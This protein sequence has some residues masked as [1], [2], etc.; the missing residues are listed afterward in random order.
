MLLAPNAAGAATGSIWHMDEKSGSLMTDSG[1]PGPKGGNIGTLKNVQVGQPGYQG[2]G[3]GFTGKSVIVVKN[4]PSIN[5]G[6]APFQFTL[7]VNTTKK[8]SA[9]VGDYDLLRKGLSSTKGGD[10]KAE[11]LGGGNAICYFRGSS[12]SKQVSASGNLADGKWHTIQC[13]KDDSKI[14]IVVDGKAKSSS[15]K[16]G[17]ITNSAS[18]AIGAKDGG[19]GGDWYTGLMDEVSFS[20]GGSAPSPAPQAQLQPQPQPDPAT[21]PP[22][23]TTP[24]PPSGSDT[25][26][27][28]APT[29]PP[30]DPSSQ[31]PTDPSSQTSTDT[32]TQTGTGTTGTDP[33]SPGAP[34][35][36]IIP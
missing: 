18:L 30:T 15:A 35:L 11:I 4:N 13:L 3:Y 31:T 21:T 23:A 33:S 29:S 20:I 9:S 1:S 8:P 7:H 16:I 34:R 10:F 5:P 14:T 25:Q 17:S 36:T 32:G 6:A 28:G 22:S 2:T 26:S 27:A 24:P 19:G 12:G